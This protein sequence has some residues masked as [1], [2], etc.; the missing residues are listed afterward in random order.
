MSI[1]FLCGHAAPPCTPEGMCACSA[2]LHEGGGGPSASSSPSALALQLAWPLPVVAGG[3]TFLR[4][5]FA[6]GVCPPPGVLCL[7]LRPPSLR[8]WVGCMCA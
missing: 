8:V 4:C 1:P 6:T 3:G 5:A 7:L 2:P